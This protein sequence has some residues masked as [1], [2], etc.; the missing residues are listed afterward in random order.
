M[1][2]WAIPNDQVIDYSPNGDDVDSF[3]QKVK[4]CIEEIFKSLLYLKTNGATAGLE[5]DSG[6]REYEIRIN[7]AD[8]CL[9]MRNA[10][11]TEWILLGEIAQYFGLTADKIAA[12]ANGGGM[13]KLTCGRLVDRPTTDVATNDMYFA[14]DDNRLYIWD[15]T[16]WRIFLS[17]HFADLFNYERYTI[18]REDLTQIGGVSHAGEILQLDEVTGKANVDITGSPARIANKVI[19]FQDLRDGHAIVYNAQKDKFVNLP[20]CPFPV[21]LSPLVN[22]QTLVFNSSLNAFHNEF[23]SGGG[24]G[25]APSTTPTIDADTIITIAKLSSEIEHLKRLT[26]NLYGALKEASLTPS[27][28]NGIE[29]DSVDTGD[30]YYTRGGISSVYINPSESTITSQDGY[31][32]SVNNTSSYV[33]TYGVPFNLETNADEM[34]PVV[35]DVFITHDMITIPETFGT[36]DAE[37]AVRVKD[38]SISYETWRWLNQGI[39]TDTQTFSRMKRVGTY[40]VRDSQ[41]AVT[42]LQATLFNR[43][44]ATNLIRPHAYFKF[45]FKHGEGGS[46]YKVYSIGYMFNE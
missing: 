32:E 26:V 16:D 8:N 19:D 7:T 29:V 4:F 43:P 46:S 44:L 11:N 15:G 33:A 2:I 27:G 14:Y 3:S 23:L 9:Y 22:G 17:R 40:Q 28:E 36:L 25:T 45:Y 35:C 41:R 20:N 13:G 24:S 21:E 30:D 6:T 1:A 42:H 18:T 39:P 5:V 37:V 38:S 10:D 34:L 12:V 31:I